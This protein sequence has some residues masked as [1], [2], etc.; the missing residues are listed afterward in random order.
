MNPFFMETP[1]KYLEFRRTEK[2]DGK[3]KKDR[4]FYLGKILLLGLALS[5]I[6]GTLQVYLSNGELYRKLI[7]LQ[8][9]GYLIIPNQKIMNSLP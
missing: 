5:Q 2:G 9:H 6:L 7:A 3:V 8:D 4:F 1:E